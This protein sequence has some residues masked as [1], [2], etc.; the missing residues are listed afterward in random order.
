M[1]PSLGGMIEGFFLGLRSIWVPGGS[2]KRSDLAGDPSGYLL[3]I[4]GS[5]FGG[6]PALAGGSFCVIVRTFLEKKI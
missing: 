4:T 6:I 1:S 3:S 2:S 5:V